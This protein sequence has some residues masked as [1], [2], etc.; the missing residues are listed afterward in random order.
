[1]KQYPIPYIYLDQSVREKM[2]KKRFKSF[3]GNVNSLIG[4]NI[5]RFT[6]FGL[7]EFAGLKKTE[8]FDIQY[9]GQKLDE[10]PFQNYQD[11]LECQSVLKKQV[12]EK[13]T[14]DFLIEKLE[15][16][17]EEET[18]Y[19]NEQGFKYIV[20]YIEGIKGS[21][22]VQS[23]YEGLIDNLYLDRLSQINIS[24]L[25]PEDKKQVICFF[26]NRVIGIIS[27]EKNLGGFRLICKI[28]KEKDYI[29]VEGEK[30]KSVENQIF[31]ICGK[32][33]SKGDLMDCEL[34]HLA[35]F[36]SNKKHCHCYTTGDEETINKRLILYC[37]S[38]DF[39]IDWYFNSSYIHSNNNGYNRP[40]WRCG[41]V[42]I[43]DKNTGKKIKKVSATKI[44]EKVLKS[45]MY[46][47]P[48]RGQ[49]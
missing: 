11:V 1:M 21:E 5:Q 46:Q 34:V 37:K 3:Q 16:K 40:E 41:K 48:K 44:Y 4:N 36:G 39:F 17:K 7:L 25:C 33:K 42:F 10:Y 15:K 14:K 30:S 47:P 31:K 8:L 24:K 29:V 45:K 22:E 18:P 23:I 2:S 19:F 27:Q 9:K 43:L 26:I 20:K 32:L 38:I 6:V 12:Y 13:V 49:H 28:F 35:F